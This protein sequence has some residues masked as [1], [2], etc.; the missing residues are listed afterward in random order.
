MSGAFEKILGSASA[1]WRNLERG[2]GILLSGEPPSADR[3]LEEAAEEAAYILGHGT[4][5]ELRESLESLPPEVVESG[6]EAIKKAIVDLTTPTGALGAAAISLLVGKAGVEGKPEAFKRLLDSV[7][8]LK[9]GVSVEEAVEY[10]SATAV[11]VVRELPEFRYYK[12]VD[13]G[14]EEAG[15]GPHV[16]QL[17]PAPVYWLGRA[18]GAGAVTGRFLAL[19]A[20][21]FGGVIGLSEVLERLR[22]SK[23]GEEASRLLRGLEVGAP[24]L[25]YVL[26]EVAEAGDRTALALPAAAAWLAGED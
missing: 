12:R 6:L 24:V 25:L 19:E 15:L 9:D 8:T 16:R 1:Y 18:V 5:P 20:L 21:S 22:E 11:E 2:F 26:G 14:L 4:P 13:E 17:V 7:R 10:L 3:L 23:V